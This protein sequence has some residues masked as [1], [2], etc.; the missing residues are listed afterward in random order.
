MFILK[1]KLEFF[2]NMLYELRMLFNSL[3]IFFD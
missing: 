2:V 3:F 1:Y